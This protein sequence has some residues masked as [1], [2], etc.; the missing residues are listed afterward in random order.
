MRLCGSR[1]VRHSCSRMSLACEV[2]VLLLEDLG[3]AR[4]AVE[5]IEGHH[6]RLGV[7]GWARAV[8]DRQLERRDEHHH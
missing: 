5:A 2:A 3:D 7:E 8:D 6:R 4:C 1:V